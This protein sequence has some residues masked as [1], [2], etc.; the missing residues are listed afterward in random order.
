MTR[1]QES[2][3]RKTEELT[4]QALVERIAMLEYEKAQLRA[5]LTILSEQ[6]KELLYRV[7][8]A[9]EPEDSSN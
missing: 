4:T 5:Q 1:N 3:E 8:Q 7:E 9:N 6:N 2:I